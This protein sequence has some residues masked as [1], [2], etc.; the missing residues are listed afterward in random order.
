[1]RL[2]YLA[3]FFIVVVSCTNNQQHDAAAVAVGD[4]LLESTLSG[5][6]F[7]SPNIGHANIVRIGD[8]LKGKLME[9]NPKLNQK[10]STVL[11]GEFDDSEATHRVK[12]VC[13]KKPLLGIRLKYD[14]DYNSFHI[15]GWWTSGL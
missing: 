2:L 7:K 6:I 4:Y 10:C 3:L 11:D 5:D 9:L 12:I 15:L 13:E 8:G 1:M 14:S